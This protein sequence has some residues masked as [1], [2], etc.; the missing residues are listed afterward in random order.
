MQGFKNFLTEDEYVLLTGDLNIGPTKRKLQPNP[1]DDAAHSQAK[2]IKMN[3]ETPTGLVNQE[4][5]EPPQIELMDAPR[6][7]ETIV[8]DEN[9][10]C[11][12]GIEQLD[13]SSASE[14]EMQMSLE[15]DV[16][17]NN[18]VNMEN[19]FTPL[20]EDMVIETEPVIVPQLSCSNESNGMDITSVVAGMDESLLLKP[21]E[22]S[23]I[24]TNDG[25]VRTDES[26]KEVKMEKYEP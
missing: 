26:I 1:T 3:E 16:S 21:K 18:T 10:E 6:P 22:E 8:L 9:V 23:K 11:M 4:M 24:E 13:D 15:E 25:M 5:I 2:K 17:V 20:D 12:N 7:L 14:I 19:E